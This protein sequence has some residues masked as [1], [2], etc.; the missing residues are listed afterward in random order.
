MVK[1][2]TLY[3]SPYQGITGQYLN[4]FTK[5]TDTARFRLD[6]NKQVFSVIANNLDYSYAQI[7]TTDGYHDLVSD[8]NFMVI[9]YGFGN[10]E[11]Y[12]YAAGT[13]I[14]NLVQ[15]ISA[16]KDSVCL[17]DTFNFMAEIS[18]TPS[19][20][21]WYLG[22]G[23]TE[24]SVRNVKHSYAK[25]GNYVVSLVT[26]RSGITDCSSTDSN[27]Y[28]VR[29]HDYPRAQFL[30][31]E[32]CL[33]DT[34]Y[35]ID[36]S[37]DNSTFSNI[38]S[39][40]WSFG[41]S[42]VSTMSNPIKYFNRIGSF[43]SRLKVANNNLCFDSVA[44]VHHVNPHPKITINAGDSCPGLNLTIKDDGS[45]DAGSVASWQWLVDSA[46]T[47]FSQSFSASFTTPGTHTLALT[48]ISDSACVS[49]A[50]DSFTIYE[51]TVAKFSIAD[52]CIGAASIAL[53][54]SVNA[55]TTEWDFAGTTYTGNSPSHT[56]PNPGNYNIK[57]LVQSAEGCK[58]SII[59]S[60][61]V[62]PLP[63]TAWSVTG[64]CSGDVY[65]FNPQ[66]D[67]TAYGSLSHQWTIDGTAENHGF[68]WN[69][70]FS[71]AGN[72]QV[73]L[74]VTDMNSCSDSSFSMVYI[75]PK[76]IAL[77]T[78]TAKC[79]G[80]LAVLTDLTVGNYTSTWVYR[81]TTSN[82]SVLF[83]VPLVQNELVKLRVQ[84]DSGCFDSTTLSL[85]FG[86]KPLVT[87]SMTGNCPDVP[88]VFSSS[89]ISVDPINSYR[90]FEN[91][92]P[93]SSLQSFNKSYPDKATYTIKLVAE[94]DKGCSDSSIQVLN[95]LDKPVLTVTKQD[96]CEG[97]D[98]V[99]AANIQLID[100]SVSQVNWLFNNKNFSGLNITDTIQTAGYYP[101]VISITSS[102][103]C[104]FNAHYRDS[105]RVFPKAVAKF[106]PNPRL[107]TLKKP[108]VS[109]ENGSQF[110]G[111]W[112]WDFGD[113]SKSSSQ[114]PIHRYDDTGKF[115][116][117]LWAN[118]S[119]NCP[120]STMDTV[121]MRPQLYC[122]NPNA[123]TPN[124]D[125]L[126]PGFIPYCDGY[127]TFNMKIWNRWGQLV[128]QTS[129][130]KAWNG[131]DAEGND[132]M[133]GV[134]VFEAI[135][136]DSNN[137]LKIIRGSFTLIR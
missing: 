79:E 87:F 53:D 88:V 80:E 101:F 74:K 109:F 59:K 102:A 81:S 131:K 73:K 57:Q 90:W 135:M 22:D 48:A 98:I 136:K 120:D 1:K 32:N 128:Y 5:T 132:A 95:I 125:G 118:N 127:V 89:V 56:F 38:S 86:A 18:Y 51:P 21:K 45:I 4:V 15:S 28:R 34:F 58:D 52:V 47:Y 71:S 110:G 93:L 44:V 67:T 119:F 129:D 65:G 104:V 19:S 62:F 116:V 27:V 92:A 69:R 123:F 113:D 61:E 37:K 105:V 115:L 9:A 124:G 122:F 108:D 25:S 54:S 91:N 84:S 26:T 50:T 33:K 78:F 11:S 29:V 35:F 83:L 106:T 103:N 49:F 64:K 55:T 63:P 130:Y 39:Y 75:N 99:I 16:S 68:I 97:A 82:D 111:I 70:L 137:E 2:V 12:G 10:F 8:S 117:T 114:N 6:N 133:E 23:R 3:S 107:S 100:H 17:G 14:R 40:S 96:V 76:P 13:N 41:D 36:S 20:I 77:A 112:L 94:T 134:Y 31:K 43:A 72:M 60:T 46:D 7:T 126:N 30:V 85:T 121:I 42:T 24:T 66:F